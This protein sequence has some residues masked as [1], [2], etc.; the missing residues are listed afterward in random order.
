MPS[1][2]NQAICA[3]CLKEPVTTLNSSYCREC[4]KAYKRE[5]YARNKL[6]IQQYY[7]GEG[8]V[9]K[10]ARKAVDNAVASGQLTRPQICSVCGIEAAIEAHH[11]DYT[12][13]LTVIWLCNTCHVEVHRV[14]A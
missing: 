11:P 12:Q 10:A 1:V 4:R 5:Y 9:A 13:P 7:R 8:A 2:D 3:R 14:A 6:A